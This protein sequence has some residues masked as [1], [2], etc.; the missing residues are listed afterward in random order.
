MIID[1]RI[2]ADRIKRLRMSYGLTQADV[3]RSLEITRSSV[4]AWEQGIASPSVAYLIKLASLFKVSTDYI[5]GLEHKTVLDISGIDDDGVKI[6][7]NMFR[8]MRDRH[9]RN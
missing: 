6:L 9:D 2:I 3:A 4:N 8:Y 1:D 7:L 5:L